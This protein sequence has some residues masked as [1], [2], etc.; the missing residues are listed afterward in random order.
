[1]SSVLQDAKTD[2]PWH[3]TFAWTA[4]VFAILLYP[5][6]LSRYSAATSP[7]FD[8][9]MHIAAGYRYWQCADYSINPEHPPLLKLIATVPVRHWP[10]QV[11]D[12]PCGAPPISNAQLIAVGY[13]LLNGNLGLDA[14]PRARSAAMLFSL[15]L[16]ITIFF[17]ARAWFGPLAAGFAALLT[18]FE[19]NLTGHGALVTTDMAIAATTLLAIFCAD[20]FLRCPTIHRLVLLGLSLGSAFASKHSAVLVPVILLF[21]F[22]AAAWFDRKSS[23]KKRNMPRL[24]VAWFSAC[25][26]GL[27][28]LWACYQ[29][30]YSALPGRA[31]SFDIAATLQSDGRSSTLF[32]HT[33]ATAA[34]CHLLPESYL[35]GLLYV[36]DNSV[37]TSFIFGQEHP[38]G[39]WYYFPVTLLVKTTLS[40]LLLLFLALG[41]RELWRIRAREFV[42]IA[43]L[44]VV[45]LLSAMAGKIDIGVRHILPVYPFLILFAASAAAFYAQRSKSLLA[46]VAALLALQCAS[47]VR[48]F[49]N[50]ISYANEA[51]GGPAKVRWVLGDSN[52]DWGQSLYQVRSYIADHGIHDCWIAWFGGQNP[53]RAGIPCRQLT[54]PSFIE[55]A[56]PDLPAVL[57]EKFSGTIF[58]SNTLT[59]YR[60]F[61]YSYFHLHPPADI[62]AG[63][64]LVFHGDFELSEVAAERHISRGWW[65]LNHQQPAQAVDEFA[66]AEPHAAFPGILHGL[67]GWALEATGKPAEARA[68]Y[69]QAAEEQAGMPAYAAARAA[70]LANVERLRDAK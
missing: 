58:V 67:Y 33:V 24:A 9:G 5:V 70:S 11:L 68:K 16:L 42:T 25:L 38:T 50:L 31:Q 35:D 57:P 55:A 64:V 26:L 40:L 28:V 63:S 2:P 53:S 23:P 4:F 62:I 22:A 43:L 21:Q 37:R 1:M 20:R 17:V 52:L 39:V 30:R 36:A 44:V 32:G 65:F 6:L 48:A 66:V 29:F 56:L 7:T 19:P 12:L 45:F 54:S 61:P 27:I 8:E 51:W 10:L 34:R 47:Y 49:P 69:A 14:L 13:R 18:V 59:N 3:S 15:L 46:V 41:S 60:I